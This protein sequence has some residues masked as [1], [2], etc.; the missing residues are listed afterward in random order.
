MDFNVA[1]QGTGSQLLTS[2][3]FPKLQQLVPC[4][5]TVCLLQSKQNLSKAIF[6][7][8]L[9]NNQK[10]WSKSGPSGLA[11]VFAEA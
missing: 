6:A 10:A 11:A 1:L 3:C 8:F 7:L 4:R 2:G 9:F 5:P